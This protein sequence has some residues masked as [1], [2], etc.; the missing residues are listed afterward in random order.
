MR[1]P[2]DPVGDPAADDVDLI[3]YASALWRRKWVILSASLAGAALAL[4]FVL[5]PAATYEARVTVGRRPGAPTDPTPGPDLRSAVEHRDVVGKALA[6]AGEGSGLAPE[7]FL[8]D[9]RLSVEAGS[10]ANT[11]LLSVRMH[12][13]RAA[14]AVANSIAR[15]AIE[16]QRRLQQE[17]RDLAQRL[18]AAQLDESRRSLDET[19]ATFNA[20]A[21]RARLPRAS[22][23]RLDRLPAQAFLS[24][25]RDPELT[26]LRTD[27]EVANTV[28]VDLARRLQ[29]SLLEQKLSSA[30]YRVVEPAVP[31]AAPI[32]PG[33]R[34]NIV[35]GLLAGFFLSVAGVLIAEMAGAVRAR[36]AQRLG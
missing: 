6:E 32:G 8:A 27:Y 29:A 17:E 35:S 10:L 23:P 5:L 26:R 4:A 1:V 16:R 28:Y 15:L 20:A 33:P 11:W 7:R 12:D 18:L 13:P 25:T 3:E 2:P 36:R 30:D 19:A 9:G 31:P 22:S 34:R 24:Y 21:A 14:S